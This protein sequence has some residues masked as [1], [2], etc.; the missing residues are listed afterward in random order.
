[1]R[2]TRSAHSIQNLKE[3]GNYGDRGVN[4]GLEKIRCGGLD[5]IQ[6]A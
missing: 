5:W 3:G 6:L 2:G 4:G 1:M